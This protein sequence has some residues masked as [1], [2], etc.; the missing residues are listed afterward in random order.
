MHK[1]WHVKVIVLWRFIYLLL[2]K[3]HIKHTSILSV[4]WFLGWSL[5][6]EVYK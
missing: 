5:V 1:N 2:F 6:C 3:K 4:E